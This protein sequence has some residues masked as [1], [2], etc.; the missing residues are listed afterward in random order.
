MKTDKERRKRICTKN[1]LG[2]GERKRKMEGR[3]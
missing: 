2:R 3:G 1:K